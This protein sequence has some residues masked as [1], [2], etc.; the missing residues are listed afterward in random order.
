MA[1]IEIHDVVIDQ[2]NELRFVDDDIAKEFKGKNYLVGTPT[3]VQLARN[4][5]ELSRNMPYKYRGGS[6]PR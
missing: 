6:G 2:P 4:L 5:K 3:M 1:D